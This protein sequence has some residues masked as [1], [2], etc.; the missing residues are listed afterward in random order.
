MWDESWVRDATV[1]ERQKSTLPPG[2]RLSSIAE[3]WERQRQLDRTLDNANSLW[4]RL[5]CD[6]CRRGGTLSAIR[7]PNSQLEHRLRF[8]SD[9]YDSGFIYGF[10]ALLQH[11]AHISIPNYRSPDRIMMVFTPYLFT[12][13]PNKKDQ[14]LE[15]HI[16]VEEKRDGNIKARKV[17]GGNKQ[18][19]YI[20]KQDV[21]SPTVTAE[22]V[23]LRCVI[24]AQENRDVA[25]V[26]IPNAFV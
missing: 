19:D 5:Y 20:T 26:D 16:F 25:V 14:L 13:Y 24:D 3:E 23:M 6:D 21:S 1:A 11:D 12:P 15:S 7:I 18:R 8:S 4:C 9:W 22:A 2:G 17:I 10:A